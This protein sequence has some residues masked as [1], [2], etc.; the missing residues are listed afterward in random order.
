MF[1]ALN[2]TFL[3]FQQDFS[4]RRGHAV[5]ASLNPPTVTAPEGFLSGSG[6]TNG[7]PQSGGPPAA[8]TPQVVG[9]VSALQGPLLVGFLCLTTS[10]TCTE[11]GLALFVTSWDSRMA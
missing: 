1:I 3:I 2:K 9:D 8:S 7:E 5:A 11:A 4:L 6:P 10:G